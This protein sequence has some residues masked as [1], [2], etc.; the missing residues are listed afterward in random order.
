MNV[1]DRFEYVLPFK[2]WMKIT[3]KRSDGVDLYLW[4]LC[5]KIFSTYHNQNFIDKNSRRAKNSCYFFF[6]FS[7]YGVHELLFLHTVRYFSFGLKEK[8]LLIFFHWIFFA[9]WKMLHLLMQLEQFDF[10]IDLNS[11]NNLLWKKEGIIIF[12][13][14]KLIRSMFNAFYRNYTMKRKGFINF[15][16]IAP[17]LLKMQ[18]CIYQHNL[19]PIHEDLFQNFH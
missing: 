8:I 14:Q 17:F 11:N 18:N 9:I 1:F 7:E 10:I 12:L 2:A 16:S 4:F 6:L 5:N 19:Q 3:S 15:I 13:L